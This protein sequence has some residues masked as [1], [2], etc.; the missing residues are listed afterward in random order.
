MDRALDRF[1]IQLLNLMQV[2]NQATADAL[3]R[4]VP[5]SPSAIALRR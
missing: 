5:L 4:Q 1:D 3:A 2:D